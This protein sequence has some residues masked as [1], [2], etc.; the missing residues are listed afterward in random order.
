MNKFWTKAVKEAKPYIPGEQINQP[1][2]LKLNT[3]ENPYPPSPKAIKAISEETGDSLRLYPT[4]T[5]DS[6]RKAIA[7]NFD[8]KHENVFVGNGSDEVLAFSFMAFF[9]RGSTIKYPSITY[10]FYPVYANL[11][12]VSVDEVPL[13][14]DFTISPEKFFNAPGGIIFPNPN[15]PTSLYLKLEAIELILKNNPHNIVIV[16]E[17][18][19]DFAETSAA[20]LINQYDNLL[21][22]QT[23]SKSRALAGLRVGF[24][25][26]HPDLIEALIRMKDSFNSYPV[27]RLA[28]A[29]AE[30]AICDSQYFK[31]TTQKIINTREWTVKEMTE[32][33]FEVLPSQANF[34]FT[35]HSKHR[36]EKLYQQLKDANILVRHFN[37]EPISDYLRITIGT[38][39][40][41]KRLVTYLKSF[42]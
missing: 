11:F 21:V 15:A 14:K 10:S 38:D 20:S 24:A 5:M 23:L 39:A 25:L 19:V 13:N 2:L 35:K 8:L 18:Y 16:D 4:P 1:N 34:I 31:E 37:T 26:G 41:M 6:L 12:N 27:D 32:L 28:L 17:A 33:G 30:A 40:D 7:N 36:G 29:G 9:E 22:I 3:N 42:I